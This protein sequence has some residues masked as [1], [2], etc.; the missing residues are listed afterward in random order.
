MLH[1]KELS[2]QCHACQQVMLI[3]KNSVTIARNTNPQFHFTQPD[4]CP[5]KRKCHF[6]LQNIIG[7]LS[8]KKT[9]RIIYFSLS[10]TKALCS[11]RNNVWRSYDKKTK[12]FLMSWHQIKFP[13]NKRNSKP[14]REPPANF[15][16]FFLWMDSYKKNSWYCWCNILSYWSSK[17]YL[18]KIM[19]VYVN[20]WSVF[21]LCRSV[22]HH[23]QGNYRSVHMHEEI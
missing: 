8:R 9:S 1:L 23:W 10:V 3:S 13:P 11:S 14:C 17:Q 20:S 4:I 7:D 16:W 6:L 15:A 22:F 18:W 5:R 12:M 2:Y 21:L 19:Y